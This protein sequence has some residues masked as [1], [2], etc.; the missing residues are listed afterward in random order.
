VVNNYKEIAMNKKQ[1]T[2]QNKKM[3]EQYEGNKR[4]EEEEEEMRV[5]AF[6]ILQ[7]VYKY[8]YKY[9]INNTYNLVSIQ[10]NYKIKVNTS[11]KIWATYGIM[12]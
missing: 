11:I 5:E 10:N 6:D 7:N 2:A 9:D 8:V 1:R 4:K 3:K 12:W